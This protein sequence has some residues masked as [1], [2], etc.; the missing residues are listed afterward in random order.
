M[1]KK[2]DYVRFIDEFDSAF[3]NIDV[4]LKSLLNKT[5]MMQVWDLTGDEQGKGVFVDVTIV[6]Y[7]LDSFLVTVKFN[8]PLD[9]NIEDIRY[10]TIN[11]IAREGEW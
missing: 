6:D 10:L 3:D 7:E 8:N 11:D 9:S 2:K 5:I 4:A 1:I